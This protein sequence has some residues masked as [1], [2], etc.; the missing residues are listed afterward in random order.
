M[1][2][3]V[4]DR[5]GREKKFYLTREGL[6]EVKKEYKTL[7]RLK[8]SRVGEESPRV[9]HSDELAPEYLAFK[10]DLDLLD[11]R[12]TTLEDVLKNAELIKVPPREERDKIH[13]GAK[14]LAEMDGQ[15]E[16]FSILGTLEADPS[17]GK[18]SNESPI[19]KTL[20]GKKVGEIV[21]VKTPLVNCSCKIIKIKYENGS[22]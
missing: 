14:V 2:W 22:N 20:L 8:Q 21:Q 4:F 15:I 12:I 7:K 17:H 3:N 9:L 6:E 5:F 1:R 13:L 11:L 18:I 10:E 16:E 19:G